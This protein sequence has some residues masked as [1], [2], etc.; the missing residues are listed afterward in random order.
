[1]KRTRSTRP[2]TTLPASWKRG[3]IASSER[4]FGY[5]RFVGIRASQSTLSTP[6]PNPKIHGTQRT[7]STPKEEAARIPTESSWYWHT[8]TR[9]AGSI[10]REPTTTQLERSVYW[11]WLVSWRII[12]PRAPYDFSS[13]TRNIHPGQARPQRKRRNHVDIILLP[14]STWM[15]SEQ[16][17]PRRLPQARKPT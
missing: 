10:P 11:K 6:R 9:K 1:M 13:A 7:I 3:D 8:R 5:R 4:A 16:R 14:S 15:E 12:P 2:T 17:R